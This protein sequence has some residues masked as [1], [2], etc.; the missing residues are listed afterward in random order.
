MGRRHYCFGGP[1]TP[2]VCSDPNALGT[3]FVIDVDRRVVVGTFSTNVLSDDERYLQV[4]LS[5]LGANTGCEDV[6]GLVSYSEQRLLDVT[7]F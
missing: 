3:A 1:S 6:G 7:V 5:E 2:R 4:S